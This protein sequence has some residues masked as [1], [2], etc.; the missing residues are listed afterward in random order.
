MRLLQAFSD[1]SASES[2]DRRLFMAG[3]VYPEEGWKSFADAWSSALR[4]SPSIDYLHMVEAQNLRDQFAGWKKP[5]RDAKLRNLA[6]VIQIFR[7]VSFQFSVSRRD[8]NHFVKSNSPKPLGKPHFECIFGIIC[9]LANW[10]EQSGLRSPIDFIFDDQEGVSVDV[11]L[12]FEQMTAGLPAPARAL[13]NSKPAFRSDK[14]FLPLQAAD[15]LAWHLRREHE[16]GEHLQL[17]RSLRNSEYHLVS[18]LPT[19]VLE[20]WF[21]GFKKVP[22]IPEIQTKSQW[23]K[24]RLEIIRAMKLGFVPPLHDPNASTEEYMRRCYDALMALNKKP[25]N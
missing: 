15:M 11:D 23:R 1:D 2:G 19:D 12:F 5:Q 16:T 24:V 18:E 8:F 4:Q 20:K 14:Q 3:Y 25:K 13:I 10:S 21:E 6:N 7:P 17:T 22:G 9:T